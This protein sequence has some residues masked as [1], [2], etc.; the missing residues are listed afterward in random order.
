[1]DSGNSF[2]HNNK[3]QM[4]GTRIYLSGRWNVA[5]MPFISNCS[6]QLVTI[7]KYESPKM[8]SGRI[9]VAGILNHS[10]YLRSTF[11]RVCKFDSVKL[12][13]ISEPFLRTRAFMRFSLWFRFHVAS[14]IFDKFRM[15][16][17]ILKNTI[18]FAVVLAAVLAGIFMTFRSNKLLA[19]Q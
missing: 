19:F 17:F 16:S 18:A 4:S 8:L 9:F 12:S 13:P 11:I 1:M 14:F 10:L 2:C 6:S 15:N 3:E 7:R 5:R